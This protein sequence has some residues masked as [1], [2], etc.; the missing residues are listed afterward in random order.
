MIELAAGLG[1]AADAVG[2]P[3][4][5]VVL[6]AQTEVAEVRE[7]AP[8]RGGSSTLPHKRNPIAAVSALACARQAPGLVAN[9]V[10]A[11][12]QEHERAAGAWH[13]EWRPLSALLVSVGSAASWLRD[14][15]E[16]LEVDERAMQTNLE[17]TGGLLL[18]ERVAGALAS[19]LGRLTAN[20]VVERLAARSIAEKR[21]FATVLAEA[22]EVRGRLSADDLAR[23]LDPSG[24]LGAADASWHG[25]SPRMPLARAGRPGDPAPRSPGSARRPRAPSFELAR[26][27][28]RDVGPTGARALESAARDPLRPARSRGVGA[29]RRTVRAGRSRARRA[30]A[31]RPARRG[32][33]T[34]VRG[35]PRRAP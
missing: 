14:C 18:A 31:A 29:A 19:E 33:R 16:H 7:V 10:A 25:R 13:A 3:A 27:R 1:E 23:L 6:L 4:Q 34:P 35:V 26:Q 8:G 5:D 17:R 30:R 12:I 28:A 11:G 20:E 2:K 9:V 32:P 15:L 22:P 21:A 24:Y